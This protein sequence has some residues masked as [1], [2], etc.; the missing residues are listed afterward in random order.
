MTMPRPQ[1]QRRT[2]ALPPLR[3]P[4]S[5]L[6]HAAEPSP[7]HAAAIWGSLL[8]KRSPTPA[9]SS[10]LSTSAVEFKPLQQKILI[11]PAMGQS[12]GVSD[13]LPQPAGVPLS[14]ELPAATPTKLNANAAAF[15]PTS[16]TN[17]RSVSGSITK[18]PKAPISMRSVEGARPGD[19]I[20]SKSSRK[21]GSTGPEMTGVKLVRCNSDRARLLHLAQDIFDGLPLK[22]SAASDLALTLNSLDFSLDS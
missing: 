16:A 5:P 4:I 6:S 8:S 15:R 3:E 10:N 21:T 14:Q 12:C 22:R 2:P 1:R 18:K 20:P 7:N 19:K 9:E 17:V 11:N 13:D